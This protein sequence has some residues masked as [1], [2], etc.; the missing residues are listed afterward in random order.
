M[1]GEL[2]AFAVVWSGM[3]DETAHYAAETAGKARYLAFSS[4]RDY[5]ARDVQFSQLKV[6]RVPNYDA[7]A[8]DRPKPGFINIPFEKNGRSDGKKS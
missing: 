1:E 5:V 6:K 4:I 2:K 7:I 3:P 8:K